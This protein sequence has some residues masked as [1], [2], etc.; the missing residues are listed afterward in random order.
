MI[1]AGNE[2]N[3]SRRLQHLHLALYRHLWRRARCLPGLDDCGLDFS[4]KLPA[5]AVT[6]WR[7]Y[8][9][10]TLPV[11]GIFRELVQRVKQPRP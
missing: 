1:E 4:L 2:G 7:I 9:H 8:R 11:A 3:L 6:V 10:A 5:I